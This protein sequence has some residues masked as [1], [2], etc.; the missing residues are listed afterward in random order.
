MSNKIILIGGFKE[1]IELCEDSDIQIAGI[2]DRTLD[3][4]LN[5]ITIF[6]N[7]QQAEG[8]YHQLKQFPFVI[9][10][11][12]PEV[13]M[14]LARYYQKIG[15]YP[16]SLIS[17]KANISKSATIGLGSVVQFGVNV[18][19]NVS[20]GNFVKL[21]TYA[22]VMHDSVISDYTTV[23]PNAVILGKVK[24]GQG[25]YIGANSTILPGLSIGDKSIIG[26]GAVVTRNVDNGQ[27]V[28]GVPAK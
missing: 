4:N 15:Y 24:I 5:G 2:F 27:I 14:H 13:R 10:P 12:I 9:A 16:T 17:K 6:G 28:K 23:A 18:S 8:L 7:D 3:K 1:I 26:A 19:S 25:C 22:N 21:N 11:D 20:I